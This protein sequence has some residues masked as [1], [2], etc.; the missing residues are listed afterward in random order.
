MI[1]I[2]TIAL[3]ISAP[4]AEDDW[5]FRAACTPNDTDLFFAEGPRDYVTL[6]TADAK[7]ICAACPVL[8]QCKQWALDTRPEHGVYGGLTTRERR[9]VI[10]RASIA[11]LPTEVAA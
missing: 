3:A 10:R 1:R 4:P 7:A 11:G 5:R 2:G 8:A 9:N 6:A